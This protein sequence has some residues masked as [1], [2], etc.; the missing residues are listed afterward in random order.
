VAAQVAGVRDQRV[1]DAIRSTPR[2]AF[3][4]AHY[5]GMAYADQ[6]VPI[7]HGQV[8][9]QPSLIAA[10]VAALELTGTETVLEVGA[11]YGYQTALLA[12][13]AAQVISIDLWPD[14]VAQARENLAGQGIGNAVLITGDGSQGVPEHAPFDAIIVSAA[15]PEVPPPL[16]GQ[17]TDGGRLVQPVGPGGGEDVVVYRKTGAGLGP[18]RVLTRASFVRLHGRYGYPAPPQ[19]PDQRPQRATERGEGPQGER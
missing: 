3:V 1:L 17:L 8:T 12:R 19:E 10:M 16:A 18:G 11:G 7:S 13:L 15:F 14:M 9:S 5:A 6:P 2:E 4:P